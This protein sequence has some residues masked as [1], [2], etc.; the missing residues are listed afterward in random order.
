MG[1]G[2][3]NKFKLDTKMTYDPRVTLTLSVGSSKYLGIEHDY[4]QFW[5][6]S[7]KAKIT[8]EGKFETI[9]LPHRQ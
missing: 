6:E 3:S 1:Q 5:K 2:Y 7:H 9:S 4:F 8:F